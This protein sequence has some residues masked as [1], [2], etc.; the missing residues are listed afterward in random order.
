MKRLAWAI[1]AATLLLPSV[2]HA[3]KV[4]VDFDPAA[5]F[6]KF[7]TYSWTT[8]TPS[9]NPLGE[10]RI[11]AAVEQ[12]LGAEGFTK[13]TGTP[14]IMI[15]TH[16]LTKE[17]KEVI[18]TGYGYGPGYYRWGGGMGTSTASVQ[19]YVK[20]TLVLDFY[21]TSTKKLAWRGVASDTVSDN[22]E[23]NSKKVTNALTKMMKQYPPPPPKTKP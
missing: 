12:A 20:G 19:T 10:D 4:T 1:A 17:E 7:K 15:S 3:Q 22:P 23:K 16:V 8:G 13:A 2:A 11:H 5:Q 18:S 14:D 21:D 9:P 6:G